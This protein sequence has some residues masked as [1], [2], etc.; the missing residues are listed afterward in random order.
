MKLSCRVVRHVSKFLKK[1]VGGLLVVQLCWEH[2][3][4]WTAGTQDLSCSL[5][6]C[7]HL[8]MFYIFHIDTVM[9]QSL[10]PPI[11]SSYL[12]MKRIRQK[13]YDRVLVLPPL[14]H[15]VIYSNKSSS[16][17]SL[18]VID[19]FCLWGSH[20]NIRADSRP[21]ISDNVGVI[22]LSW[23]ID[24]NNILALEK[25]HVLHIWRYINKSML[26]G[27]IA[28]GDPVWNAFCDDW[29]PHV[30]TTTTTRSIDGHR[31]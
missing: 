20:I 7:V 8:F 14:S 26:E 29:L 28:P 4:I 13:Q 31:S 11:M 25:S 19:S 12:E 3:G 21:D 24:H 23:Q 15:T 6:V 27:T 2:E 16:V 5:G 10:E 22:I 30:H 17:L 9:C 1:A 18:L